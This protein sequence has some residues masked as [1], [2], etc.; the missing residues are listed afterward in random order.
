MTNPFLYLSFPTHNSTPAPSH[1]HHDYL[2]RTLFPAPCPSTDLVA[3]PCVRPS[4]LVLDT[5]PR[6]PVLRHHLQPLMMMIVTVV[7]MTVAVMVM[8]VDFEPIYFVEFPKQ[9]TFNWEILLGTLSLA[10]AACSGAILS[11]GGNQT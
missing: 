7:L 11:G 2:P 4:R 1:S 3:D 9:I 10:M 6:P 5:V 8:I